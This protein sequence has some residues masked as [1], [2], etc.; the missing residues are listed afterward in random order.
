MIIHYKVSGHGTP[1]ILLHG[2]GRDLSYFAKLQEYLA[3]RFTVYALD[4]PGFG[5]SSEPAEVWS[6]VDYA[7][8][9]RQFMRQLSIIQPILLGHSFGGKI[10]LN[11]AASNLVAVE[12]IIL[13][14]SSGI[15]L[16]RTLKIR[17][18]VF[19]FKLLKFFGWLPIIKHRIEL[20]KHRFGSSDYQRVSG[21]MR[22]ILVKAIHE[23]VKALLPCITVPTLLVWG[24]QDLETP[25]SAGRIMERAISH[26][27]LKIITGSGHFPFLDNWEMVKIE[28]DNF[29]P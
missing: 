18:Q 27:Q 11:L 29:L 1:I 22:K 15:Q 13:I 23:D 20:Y 26:A 14:G 16:T 25:L 4:L 9:V 12:K 5:L 28:L 7:N 21:I 19:G 17:A 3:E 2:W 8:L 6:S 24:E 10:V